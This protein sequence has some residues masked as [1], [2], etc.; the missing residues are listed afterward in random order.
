MFLVVR[1]PRKTVAPVSHKMGDVK[2]RLERLESPRTVSALGV[3][4]YR[5]GIG[6]G[7]TVEIGDSLDKPFGLLILRPHAIWGT[8]HG[9]RCVIRETSDDN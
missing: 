6:I 3:R 9:R 2:E 7:V 5:D 4:L 8:V 1:T